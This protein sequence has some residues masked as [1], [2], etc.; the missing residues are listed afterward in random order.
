MTAILLSLLLAQESD[1]ALRVSWGEPSS[2]DPHQAV[3]L[4]ESRYVSA[5]FE[6]LTT[7]EA[8]G[9]TV[10][11]GMAET[12]TVEGKVWT[13]TLREAKWSDGKP[14]TAEDFVRGWRR[15]VRGPY[16]PLFDLFQNVRPFRDGLEADALIAQIDDFSEA[17]RKRTAER[18]RQIAQVR[19]VAALKRR[20][21][22]VE[23]RPDVG[24]EDLGFVA[25]D[26]RT[27]RVTL[28]RDAPWLPD[29]LSFM[30]FAPSSGR[31]ATNGPYLLD[32][33]APVSITFRRNPDYWDAEARQAPATIVASI[34]LPG[35]APEKFRRGLLDW[36]SGDQIPPEK[37][38]DAVRFDAWGTFFLRFNASRPP[39]DAPG[40]RSAVSQAVDRAP[41]AKAAGA[42][43]ARSLVP[44]GFPGYEPA[45]V[46]PRD[47]AAAMRALL[48]ATGFDLSK[49]PRVNLLTDDSKESVAVGEALK[50]QLE[51]SLGFHVRLHS[52][53][54]PAYREALASGAYHAALDAWMGDYFHPAAFLEPWDA[55]PGP[56]ESLSGA[57][58]ALLKKAPFVPL[59]YAS[60][61]YL[62]SE[63]VSGLSPNPMSRFPLKHVRLKK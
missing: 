48:K 50:T 40:V 4:V 46:P 5:L 34:D 57:E 56:G 43:P 38:K 42:N 49:L 47:R 33:Q 16:G 26:A 60:D 27:L 61:A 14:V 39:F 51:K 30:S 1:A 58:A 29:Q 7:H 36:V 9:V 44:P 24:E 21:I 35:V 19:H 8:D 12:W 2:L 23:A 54:W 10:A 25:V 15:G 55:A 31:K 3:T 45:K 13:F 17:D 6:G 28:D 18:L 59:Y 62:V 22:A 20:G 53:K 63:K 41:I 32:S 52:M 11:P 37:R